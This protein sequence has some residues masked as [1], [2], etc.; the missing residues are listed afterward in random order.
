MARV[1]MGNQALPA[2]VVHVGDVIQIWVIN[3]VY[4][5][6]IQDHNISVTDPEASELAG[7]LQTLSTSELDQKWGAVAQQFLGSL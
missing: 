3:G 4:H 1:I 7:D 2:K 5:L 6:C